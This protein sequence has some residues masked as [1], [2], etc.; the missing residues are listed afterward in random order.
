[1]SDFI[2]FAVVAVIAVI[3]TVY[4]YPNLNADS[5]AN[6]EP[7]AGTSTT[8]SGASDEDLMETLN[9]SLERANQAL[10]EANRKLEDQNTFENIDGTTY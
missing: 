10:E 7:A 9:R 2:K 3:G 5:V 6:I 1:M 8:V 4:F